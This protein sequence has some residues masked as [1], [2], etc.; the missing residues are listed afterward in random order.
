MWNY[1]IRKWISDNKGEKERF[2]VKTLIFR[3]NFTKFY[4]ESSMMKKL[5]LLILPTT[6]LLYDL[7]VSPENEKK[8]GFYVI[9]SHKM[10]I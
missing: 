10:Y 6:L 2:A 7:S 5:S 9:P 8:L 4:Y 1:E 3:K